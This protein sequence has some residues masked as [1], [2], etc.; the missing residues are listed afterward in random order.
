MNQLHSHIQGR[1]RSKYYLAL[2]YFVWVMYMLIIN[3]YGNAEGFFRHLQNQEKSIFII[4]LA[5]V[6]KPKM[7]SATLRA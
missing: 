6:V 2:R 7:N 1:S 4:P 5:I 3:I